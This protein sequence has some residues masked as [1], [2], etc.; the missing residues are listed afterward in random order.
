LLLGGSSSFFLLVAICEWLENQDPRWDGVRGSKLYFLSNDGSTSAHDDDREP[1]FCLLTPGVLEP[2]CFW[3]ALWRAL[4]PRG[5]GSA[6]Q[7]TLLCEGFCVCWGHCL[8]M[9]AVI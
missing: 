8:R 6:W 4:T 9:Y 5:G 7:Y 1:R 2:G 3:S